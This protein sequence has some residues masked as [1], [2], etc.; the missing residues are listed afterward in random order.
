[1]SNLIVPLV[2]GFF[3]GAFFFGGLAWTIAKGLQ[4]RHPAPIFA[5]SYLLRLC[6][7]VGGFMLISS[8]QAERVLAAVVGCMGARLFVTWWV[9][10]S[11]VCT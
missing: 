5:L 1:M 6:V 11:G 3:L 4:A 2:C 7:V 10:R 8:G 9:R